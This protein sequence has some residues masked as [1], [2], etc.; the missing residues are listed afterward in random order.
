MNSVV[1]FLLR[2]QS[3]VQWFYVLVPAISI[4]GL[5]IYRKRHNNQMPPWRARIVVICLI[6]ISIGLHLWVG[7][8]R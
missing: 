2:H 4:I 3:L 1:N 5:S 8:H 6:L 7:L